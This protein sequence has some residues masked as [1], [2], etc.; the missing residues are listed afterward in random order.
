MSRGSSFGAAPLTTMLPLPQLNNGA[1][2]KGWN[3]MLR[4]MSVIVMVAAVV[5]T[6]LTAFAAMAGRGGGA[7]SIGG[8]VPSLTGPRTFGAGVFPGHG[9]DHGR[10]HRGRFFAGALAPDYSFSY[11]PSCWRWR[12]APLGFTRVYVCDN[13]WGN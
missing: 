13:D 4:K 2:T 1:A 7:H 10:F 3:M 9:F 8:G 11:D 12:P 5:M 6:P